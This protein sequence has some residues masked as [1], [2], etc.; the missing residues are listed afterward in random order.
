MSLFSSEMRGSAAR[1]CKFAKTVEFGAFRGRIYG[2]NYICIKLFETFSLL[3][4]VPDGFSHCSRL[5]SSFFR[6]A[7][8]GA[9]GEE[10]GGSGADGSQGLGLGAGL[11]SF[12]FHA[13]TA[14]G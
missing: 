1:L 12:I 11:R 5:I 4:N 14:R 6:S 7:C 9:C 3:G 13:Q 2:I 8:T 10:A